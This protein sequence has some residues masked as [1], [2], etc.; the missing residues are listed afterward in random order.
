[1]WNSFPGGLVTLPYY[2]DT[3]SRLP[4]NQQSS[5]SAAVLVTGGQKNK[6]ASQFTAVIYSQHQ[7]GSPLVPATSSGPLLHLLRVVSRSQH[8]ARV[9]MDFKWSDNV[10][11]QLKKI[12]GK[13]LLIT[14]G[15]YLLCC[16]FSFLL[17]FDAILMTCLFKIVVVWASDAPKPPPS[18]W[19]SLTR[20]IP[21]HIVVPQQKQNIGERFRY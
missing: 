16:S 5:A 18:R 19:P 21:L 4:W 3:P 6:N 13:R 20:G 7:T 11:K 9:R 15:F 17:S 12:T 8:V 1:M 10:N 14:D 2:A